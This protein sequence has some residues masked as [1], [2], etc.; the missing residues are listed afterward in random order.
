M[1]SYVSAERIMYKLLKYPEYKGMETL[2][3]VDQKHIKE[4]RGGKS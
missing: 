2:I 3:K 4:G 1:I